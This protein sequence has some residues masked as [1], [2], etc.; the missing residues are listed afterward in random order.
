[1][2][3]NHTPMSREETL[4]T[5][6]TLTKGIKFAMLTVVT[7][8]GHLK[9][10]PMTTQDSEFDGDVWFLGGKDTEQVRNMQ[11]RPE[12]NVSYA[13]HGK[14]NYISI[15]GTAQMVEDPAKLDELWSDGYKAYF[16]GGKA[17]PNIQLIKIEAHGAEYWGSD[18]KLKNL[19]SQ[20]R[21]AV[22]GKPA[23]DLGTN[24]TV[25]L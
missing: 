2:D 23:T 16:P 21:A 9:S 3:T 18:G 11:A 20:A 15:A 13:D 10:H 25:K 4:K 14:H 19:F 5:I 7:D 17:D 24:E 12:V 1:M 22:T 8:S 6:T